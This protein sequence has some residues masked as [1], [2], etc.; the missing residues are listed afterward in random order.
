MKIKL[1][2]NVP[3]GLAGR[4]DA[5]GH[6]VDTAQQE[7]LAGGTDEELWRAVLREQRFLITQDMDF[8]DARRFAPGTDP[9]MLLIRLYSPSR[10]SLTER[11][12][13]VFRSE[14]VEAWSECFVVVSESKIRVRRPAP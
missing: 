14:N 5:L 1:D 7:N 2:E 11:I 3:L 9:G 13:E 10:T 4:L 12:E 8:S 6:D